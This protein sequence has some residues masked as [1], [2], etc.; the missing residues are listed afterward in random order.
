[1]C[2]S[3]SPSCDKEVP[4][5]AHALSADH[6]AVFVPRLCVAALPVSGANPLSPSPLLV[7]R[8][9]FA[10]FFPWFLAALRT[11]NRNLALWLHRVRVSP[12]APAALLSMSEPAM[13]GFV[14]RDRAEQLLYKC[15]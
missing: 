13:H 8:A 3:G 15:V 5:D 4:Y 9:S 7:S 2:A 10:A 12:L 6:C 14:A 11:I 1:M